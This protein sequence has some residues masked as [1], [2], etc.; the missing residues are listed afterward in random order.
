MPKKLYNIKVTMSNRGADST[1]GGPISGV[2][3]GSNDEGT[4]L[5]EIGNFSDRTSNGYAVTTMS[6]NNTAVAYDTVRISVN[7]WGNQSSS[8][9]VIGDIYIGGTDVGANGAWAE[10]KPL[11]W[12]TE[13]PITYTY[14][15]TAMSGWISGGCSACASS[16]LN[17]GTYPAWKAFNKATSSSDIWFAGSSPLPHW[18]QLTMPRPL[19]NI[20]VSLTNRYSS[21]G[22]GGIDGIIYGS[23]D[24][25]GTLV[26]IGSF[27][28]RDP[29][30]G[31]SSTITCN[32]T[33]AAY[34]TVR[35]LFTKWGDAN[36]N[37]VTTGGVGVGAMSVTGTDIGANGGWANINEDPNPIVRQPMAAMSGE[38]SQ[39]CVAAASSKYGASYSPT[40]AFNRAAGE[41]GWIS[42]TSDTAPWLRL[43]MPEPLYNIKVTIINRGGSTGETNGPIDGTISGSTDGAE[44]TVLSSFSGR[45]GSTREQCTSHC[46]GNKIAYSRV[47]IDITNWY[48]KQS[49]VFFS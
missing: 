3:Y 34:K 5:T 7:T 18:L 46:L 19:Y 48:N 20:S 35:V 14:P 33:T 17:N 42:L 1:S 27:T 36:G 8:N 28:G 47:R 39:D 21:D 43:T 38:F 6:C 41:N 12:K 11:I 26:Q 16:C 23:N 24:D 31:K 25:G 13:N 32:N 30:T 10:A 9:A 15:S 4:T 37:P 22:K 49:Y 45:N 40:Y 29:A 2:I 44:Y